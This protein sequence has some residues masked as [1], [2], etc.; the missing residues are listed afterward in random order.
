MKKKLAVLICALV[1]AVG[2]VPG[3]AFAATANLQPGGTQLQ[4]QDKD[5]SHC[6]IKFTDKQ[7]KGDA[8]ATWQLYFVKGKNTPV[9]PEF[10]LYLNGTKIAKSD[11]KVTYYLNY[12][13]GNK[14]VS[15]K[16]SASNL[17]ASASPDANVDD[18]S[19]S[20]RY[21]ITPVKGSGYSGKFASEVA[22]VV[23]ADEYAFG[24]YMAIYMEKAR[25][26]WRYAINGMNHN[27][28]V[29]PQNKAKATL[30]SIVAYKCSTAG[31]GRM[32]QDGIKLLPKNYT[33]SYYKARKDAVQKNS[34]PAS[35]AI[36]GKKLKSVPTTVG[37]YVVIVKGVKPYYG[38]SSFLV[39]IQGTLSDTKI[40]GISNKT[41]NGKYIEPGVKVT[42]QGQTLKEGV[43]YDVTY[44]KNLKAGISTATI[45]GS[46][47][48]T[49]TDGVIDHVDTPRFFTGS[50]MVKFKIAKNSKKSWK[51]NTMKASAKTITV[52]GGAIRAKNGYTVSV[53]K[54]FS[55]SK[56]QGTVSYAKLEG[57]EQ[58]VVTK[59]GAV[60]IDRHIGR[61]REN[62]QEDQV[63]H[64][65]VKVK[66][67]GT[68]QY[69]ALQKIVNL[70]I[71]V[72]K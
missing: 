61:L 39:D 16:W 38:Q 47:V 22:E 32:E 10:D 3:L 6:A 2:L 59:S 13:R 58:F 23:V 63:Y 36:V 40:S 33:V 62:S 55:V 60:K 24:R 20:Y 11:Y 51:D 46:K 17:I 71:R 14:E 9:K 54:A 29:I 57:P 67:A 41:E 35:S 65:K 43:D 21:V 44:K 18:M 45:T 8:N 31:E 26:K 42:Y 53:K 27:Y 28:Y 72:A 7:H 12:W 70:E 52:S 25:E 48:L 64:L 4:I 66:A 56:A 5:L 30:S 15:K 37:S 49:F 50:K 1:L 69:Y 68:K 34:S 19:S